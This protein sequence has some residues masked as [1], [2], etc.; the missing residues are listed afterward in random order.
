MAYSTSSPP[1]MI[2]QRVGAN[3][4]AMWMYDSTDAA[5]SVRVDGYITDA[6]DLGIA[7]GDLIFQT[8]SA[9][10]TVAHI[11]VVVTVTSGG[12]CDL[13]NGTAITATN[14]D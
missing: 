10:G 7:V 14:S 4:A 9:G 5:T 2:G 3:G 1:A 11:Y 6:D 8:D 12:S 13:S